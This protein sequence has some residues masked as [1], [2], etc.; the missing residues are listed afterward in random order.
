MSKR[1][2]IRPR[3]LEPPQP[4]QKCEQERH[5]LEPIVEAFLYRA[6][7]SHPQLAPIVLAQAA[8]FLATS[9]GDYSRAMQY[10]RQLLPQLKDPR[11]QPSVCRELL[12]DGGHLPGLQEQ[13]AGVARDLLKIRSLSCLT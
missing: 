10:Y 11:E 7:H 12:R 9:M 3:P 4:G 8:R 1:P 13:P 5:S 2:V 6:K